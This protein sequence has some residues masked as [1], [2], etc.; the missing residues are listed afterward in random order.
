MDQTSSDKNRLHE[1][2]REFLSKV[3]SIKEPQFHEF[4]IKQVY[5]D[6][7]GDPWRGKPG[8][9]YF[10]LGNEIKYVGKGTARWGV[11]YRVYKGLN[12]IGL[13][14]FNRADP[15]PSWSDMLNDPRS[16]VGIFEFDLSDFY[17]PVSLEAFLIPSLSP[18]LNKRGKAR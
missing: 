18:E 17:W 14:N 4:D 6:H 7:N 16:K 3:P 2:V 13:T 5:P 11:G 8:I 12:K 15:K 9:Y 10:S 1:L